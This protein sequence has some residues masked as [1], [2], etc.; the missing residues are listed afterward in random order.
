MDSNSRQKYLKFSVEFWITESE[1]DDSRE[2]AKHAK[3]GENRK[4]F[5]FAPWRLGAIH[6]VEVVLLKI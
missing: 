4:I 6:I 3:F 5:F 1:K 2:D